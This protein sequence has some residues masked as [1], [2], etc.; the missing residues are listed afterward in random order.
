VQSLT[1]LSAAHVGLRVGANAFH[2]KRDKDQVD[3]DKVDAQMDICDI[4]KQL[5]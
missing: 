2:I 5:P 1:A 3:G 4:L